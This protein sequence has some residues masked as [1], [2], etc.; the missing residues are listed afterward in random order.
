[1]W[2]GP[3]RPGT[4]LGLPDGQ[5]AVVTLHRPDNVDDPEALRSI[6]EAIAVISRCV[7]VVFPLHPRT[8]ARAAAAGLERVLADEP[9]I[10]DTKPL[11]YLDFMGLLADAGLVLTDSGGI[12]EETTVLGVPCL[13][14]RPSTERPITVTSGTNRVVGSDPER[15]VEEALTVLESTTRPAGIPE[16]WDG[17]AGERIVENLRSQLYPGVPAAA[18]GRR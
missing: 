2:R 4:R 10:F 11:G 18:S 12:Q 16:L 6:F 7:P 5:Y 9:G 8:R 15:I 1:M 13:T 3:G 17:R 14:L